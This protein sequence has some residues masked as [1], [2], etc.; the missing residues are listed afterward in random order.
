MT[1]MTKLDQLRRPAGFQVLLNQ[2]LRVREGDDVIQHGMHGAQGGCFRHI[3][4]YGREPASQIRPLRAFRKP[5]SRGNVRVISPQQICEVSD[6]PKA[7][8]RAGVA[9]RPC[10]IRSW[11]QSREQSEMGARGKAYEDHPA[12]VGTPLPGAVAHCFNSVSHVLGGC[13]CRSFRGHPIAGVGDHVSPSA[14]GFP[15]AIVARQRSGDLPSTD[16]R[17]Q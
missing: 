9:P 15:E 10:E 12:V 2:P 7:H 13:G 8:D 16:L 5:S 14:P 11:C 1:P 4:V 6:T 3:V 17:S